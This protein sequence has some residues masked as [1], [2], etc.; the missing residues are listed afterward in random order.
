ML[1]MAAI[2]VGLRVRFRRFAFGVCT[3]ALSSIKLIVI[4]S[5]AYS[6]GAKAAFKSACKQRKIEAKSD[7]FHEL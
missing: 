5:N 3:G 6:T 1:V 4:G 2:A 7:F